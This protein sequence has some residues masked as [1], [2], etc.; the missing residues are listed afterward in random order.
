MHSCNCSCSSCFTRIIHFNHHFHDDHQKHTIIDGGGTAKAKS[1][2]DGLDRI[3]LR[4][5]VLLENFAVLC[6]VQCPFSRLIMIPCFRRIITLFQLDCIKFNHY[7][8]HRDY[9]SLWWSELAFDQF[10]V[11][12]AA[13][14]D[15]AGQKR[16]KSSSNRLPKYSDILRAKAHHE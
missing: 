7:D 9:N 15:A 5:M 13:F 8:D 11:G 1:G 10:S 16:P 6:N 4:K 14:S 2:W 3:Q 12:F